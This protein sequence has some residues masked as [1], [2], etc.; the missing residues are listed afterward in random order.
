MPPSNN[1]DPTQQTPTPT[2]EVTPPAPIISSQPMTPGVPLVANKPSHMKLILIII[3]AVLILAGIAVGLFLMLGSN[4]KTGSKS[5]IDKAVAT[6]TAGKDVSDRSDGTLDVSSN[7]VDGN[8]GIADQTLTAKLNQ[9]V[10]LKNGLSLMITKVERNFTGF[11]AK[12]LSV[13]SDEEV[14]AL[15][16]VA[17]S[18]NT[19]GNGVPNS[20]LTLVSPSSAKITPE[21]VSSLA[22]V[23]G[24]FDSGSGIDQGKQVSGRVLYV[25]KKDEAPLTFKYSAQY[26]NYT[27]DAIVTIAATINL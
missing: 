26:K 24:K 9:Q 18:R 27:T 3:I 21:F 8:K 12:Y 17:G 7:T 13:K 16:L 2:P 19:S 20:A 10:N 4:S 22:K 25:V 11:D 15:T 5:V 23:D 6:V 1:P 14:V